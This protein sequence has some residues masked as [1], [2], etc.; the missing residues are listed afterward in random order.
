MDEELTLREDAEEQMIADDEMATFDPTASLSDDD[1]AAALGY[2]TTLSEPL[3]PQDEMDTAED[4][5]VETADESPGT[6]EAADEDVGENLQESSEKLEE[7][8]DTDDEQTREIEEIRKE[9]EALQEEVYGEKTED[10]DTTG[11]A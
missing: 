7:T 5:E 3:L 10:T 2:H 6:A 11:Q 1:I 8:D 9:L 4:E